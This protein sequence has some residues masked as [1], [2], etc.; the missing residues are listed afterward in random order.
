MTEYIFL[1]R[2]RCLHESQRKTLW[3]SFVNPKKSRRSRSQMF[4]KIG[5][6]NFFEKFQRKRFLME[7]LFNKVAGLKTCNFIKK[8]LQRKCFPVNFRKFLKTLLPFK[9]VCEGASLVKILQ[10]YY[11]NIFGI[12]RRWFRKMPIKK[13]NE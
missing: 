3:L 12:N 8:R 11:F 9:R 13:N 1:Y 2:K 7:S 10:S 5:V 6:L 4:L